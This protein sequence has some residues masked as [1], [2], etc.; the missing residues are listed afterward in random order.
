M[1]LGSY[2][3]T[4]FSIKV[5]TDDQRT[6]QVC[7]FPAM[8]NPDSLT[9]KF[10]TKFAKPQG[11]GRSAQT[12]KYVNNPPEE[13][14]LKLILDDY[15]VLRNPISFTGKEVSANANA[16]YLSVGGNDTAYDVTSTLGW[17]TYFLK[18]CWMPYSQAHQPL[19]LKI[20]WGGISFPCRLSSVDIKYTRFG[21]DGKPTAAELDI[22]LKGDQSK[23]R[24][25]LTDNFSSPD[26]T[27]MRIVK[28]GDTLPLLCQQIY[29]DS[30]YYPT[31]A[32]ANGLNNFR[33]LQ[34]GQKLYFPPLT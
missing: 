13:M 31:V 9:T 6:D 26:L 25:N 34:I 17:I 32:Q 16:N 11:I 18:F 33:N 8:F 3:L 7:E 14:K 29:G 19:F 27:H 21:R 23:E 4:K 20:V 30:S 5:F 15:Y 12:L 22:A 28:S 2:K 10:S 1:T 24:Q